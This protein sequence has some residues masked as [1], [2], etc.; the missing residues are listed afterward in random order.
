MPFFGSIAFNSF[1]SCNFSELIHYN[2]KIVSLD[3]CLPTDN[4]LSESIMEKDVLGLQ[5]KDKCMQSI[6]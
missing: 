3:L 5:S 2:H 1:F 6:K 4:K